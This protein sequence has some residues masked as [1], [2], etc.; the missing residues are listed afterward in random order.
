MPKKGIWND[1]KEADLLLL[2]GQG[3]GCGRIAKKMGTTKSTIVGKLWRMRG[4]EPVEAPFLEEGVPSLEKIVEWK[5]A[6][7]DLEKQRIFLAG[8]IEAAEDA[9]RLY[10]KV[11]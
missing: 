9:R 3:L 1:E 7:A 11:Q 10:P 6:L 4:G 5:E 2:R 8:M